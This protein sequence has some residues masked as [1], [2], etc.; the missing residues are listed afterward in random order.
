MRLKPFHD[1]VI[2]EEIDKSTVTPGG[3]LIPDTVEDDAAPS[4]GKVLAVGPGRTVIEG[5]IHKLSPMSVKVGDEVL[6]DNYAADEVEVDGKKLLVVSEEDILC[7]V[8]T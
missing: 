7:G 2:I 1:N 5:N 4:R 8:E 3:I 6:F